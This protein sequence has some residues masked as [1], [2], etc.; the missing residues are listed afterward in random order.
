MK[1]QI[2]ID[3]K[4]FYDVIVPIAEKL[5]WDKPDLYKEVFRLREYLKTNRTNLRSS[6][7]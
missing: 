3:V 4:D 6:N 5:R 7:L 2:K 1:I